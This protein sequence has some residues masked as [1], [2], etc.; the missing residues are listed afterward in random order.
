MNDKKPI[1]SIII[2]TYNSSDFINIAINSVLD[3]SFKKWE[4][5]IIDDNSTD[6]TLKIIK[7]YTSSNSNIKI[8]KLPFNVGAANARNFGIKKAKGRFIAF[9]DSDDYWVPNKLAIQYEFFKKN[10]DYKILCSNYIVKKN[11]MK[12]IGKK[13]I[14]KKNL[15]FK[16]IICSNSICTSSAVYDTKF[17]NK[18][19]MPNL[20]RRQDWGLWMKILKLD[21]SYKAYCVQSPLVIK[22]EHKNS[23]S[24]NKLSVLYYNFAVVKKY[25]DVSFSKAVKITIINSFRVLIRK[26]KS[27]LF[28]S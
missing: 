7:K 23:L 12:N 11:S 16:D 4:L 8:I 20:K 28:F 17:V 15:N 1:F 26:L 18:V 24:A 2:P 3:Q 19:Y 14:F 21:D 27:G 25:G 13:V 6:D 9:L 22:I 10:S 5:I